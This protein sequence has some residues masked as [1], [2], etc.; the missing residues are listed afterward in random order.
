MPRRWGRARRWEAASPPCP[1]GSG[2]RACLRVL[3]NAGER[4]DGEEQ[5]PEAEA[6]PVHQFPEITEFLHERWAGGGE[7]DAWVETADGAPAAGVPARGARPYCHQRVAALRRMW[8]GLLCGGTD[9]A[10][11]PRLG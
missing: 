6:Y 8:A 2:I 7:P 10:A 1:C 4:A 5:F 9:R 3:V 11:R